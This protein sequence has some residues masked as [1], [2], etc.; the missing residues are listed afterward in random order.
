M[1]YELVWPSSKEVF[2]YSTLIT[3]AAPS[4]DGKWLWVLREKG[5]FLEEGKVHLEATCKQFW[6][7]FWRAS[8][9]LALSC[10]VN[11]L[12][13]GRLSFFSIPQAQ[14]GKGDAICGE[15]GRAASGFLFGKVLEDVL[16]GMVMC[17]I[18][19]DWVKGFSRPGLWT[20]TWQWKIPNNVWGLPHTS[21][22]ALLA[23]EPGEE[24]M[25]SWNA[26]WSWVKRWRFGSTNSKVIF[27]WKQKGLPLLEMSLHLEVITGDQGLF[28]KHKIKNGA[29]LTVGNR[30]QH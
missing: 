18:F 7:S 10:R 17:V 15:A 30:R 6:P 21:A 9:L 20:W 4:F 16:W 1:I 12:C 13:L 29:S 23:S 8:L 11:R 24:G 28:L 19:H 5:K 25:V 22:W 26:E 14:K 2:K 3:N 27:I